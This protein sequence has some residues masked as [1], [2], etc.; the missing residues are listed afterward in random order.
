MLPGQRGSFGSLGRPSVAELKQRM[1]EED[2]MDATSFHQVVIQP[3]EEEQNYL[4]FRFKWIGDALGSWKLLLII[5]MA[6]IFTVANGVIIQV[7]QEKYGMNIGEILFF[8]SLLIVIIMT[9]ATSGTPILDLN[10]GEDRKTVLIG[11]VTLSIASIT[12]VMCLTNISIAAAFCCVIM[13]QPVALLVEKNWRFPFTWDDFKVF[14]LCLLGLGLI[15]I[16]WHGHHILGIALGLITLILSYFYEV[17]SKSLIHQVNLI[18]MVYVSNIIATVLS[19][20]ILIALRPTWLHLLTVGLIALMTLFY[21]LSL[22]L[23]FRINTAFKD[24]FVHV[25]FYLHVFLGFVADYFLK[26]EHTSLY[27]LAGAFFIVIGSYYGTNSIIFSRFW[28]VLRHGTPQA[29]MA[30]DGH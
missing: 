27:N 22:E 13:I 30:L 9:I 2:I 18:K 11:S 14:A 5:V 4:V 28:N 20:P 16:P 23:I 6:S 3:Q 8:R 19:I 12:F 15:G 17:N 1:I 24:E 29:P 25:V 21:L 26:L 10:V 7:V